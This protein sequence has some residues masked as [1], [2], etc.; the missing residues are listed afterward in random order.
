MDKKFA[1]N[2]NTLER[3]EDHY[4]NITPQTERFNDWMMPYLVDY[5]PSSGRVLDVGCGM[6]RTLAE[7]KKC[8]NGDSYLLGI[9]ISNVALRKASEH[10]KDFE[11]IQSDGG[12]SIPEGG[13][14]L[15]ICSQTLEH[16]DN[17]I[18]IIDDMKKSLNPGG[19]LF[20]TVPYP[21]SSLD[22]GVKLH[23][24]RFWPKDFNLLLNRCKTIKHGINHLIV[25]WQK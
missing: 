11:F 22:N 13:F 23:H 5:I 19:T 3:M 7:V 18:E 25:I 17:P 24:W 16:V 10:Y 4:A 21:N 14:D 15:I 20:I 1:K 9:D 8:M 12:A 6:G 2:P